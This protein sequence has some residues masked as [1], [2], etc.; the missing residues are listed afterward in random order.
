LIEVDHLTKHYGTFVAVDDLSFTVAPGEIVGL[1]GPNGAGKT[2]TLRCLVGILRPTT[3]ALRVFGHDL[4]TDAVEAK[5][6]LAWMPDE[7]HLF[8]YLT[9]REH[10]QLTARLYG[11]PGGA[12]RGTA[13]L[14]ELELDDKANA[15]PGELSR[16]MKQKLAIACG[17]LHEPAALLFDEPLTGLDPYGIRR[18]KGT[19]VE[20][21]KRG[22]AIVVSSHLLHLVEEIADRVLIVQAGRRIA[23]GTLDEIRAAA[24]GLARDASLEDIFLT[25]TGRVTAGAEAAPAEPFGA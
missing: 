7:P 2:T 13:L 18:M 21:K 11:V 1:V 19:I 8:E 20:R 22:A 10:L 9:V 15:L 5:R 14:E 3:G 17:L 24:P 16:G 6:R 25:V 23:L 12:E 4:V